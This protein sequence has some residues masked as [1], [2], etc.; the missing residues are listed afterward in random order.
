MRR[1]V[2]W[3]VLALLLV[4][5]FILA[6]NVGLV[7]AQ[8]PETVYVNS[9]GSVSPSNAPISNVNNVTYTFTGNISY[10]TYYGIVIERNNIVIDGN[11]YT[12]QGNQSS[13]GISLTD[14]SNVT[15]KNI[16]IENFQNGFSLSA[17][18]NTIVSGNNV[19]ANT[20]VGIML[21]ASFS[22]SISGNS[23]TANSGFGVGLFSSSENSI[24]GNTFTDDGLTVSDSYQNSVENNTVNGKP[25]VYLEGVTDYTVGD[26]GQVILVSCDGITV[27][28]LTLSSASFAAQL[29]ET[30]NSII[31]GNN[32]TANSNNG[33]LLEFSSGNTVS[34]NTALSNTFGQGISLYYSSNNT[35]D[36]NKAIANGIG[37]QLFVSSGNT[38]SGNIASSNIGG[39]ELLS[40]SDNTVSGNTATGSNDYGIDLVL[41]S[42]N[43]VTGNTVSSNYLG[44]ISLDASSN[45]TICHNNFIGKHSPSL[46]NN[47]SV[48]RERLGQRLPIWR[49]LLERLS[50]EVSQCV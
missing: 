22:N 39:I 42:D 45:N 32:M 6:F 18:N 31:S 7:R 24:N 5:T 17:S 30:N 43:N 38:V 50:N 48:C 14:T 44:G 16:N 49:K 4:V 46:K 9:D 35:V 19:T 36:G 15:I 29:W 23:I 11:G 12:E 21:G 41:S 28:N 37:I 47:L 20:Y 34:G 10:P 27:E 25:L 26:A 13:N 8:A 40:S 3:I 2:C 33:I 1:I